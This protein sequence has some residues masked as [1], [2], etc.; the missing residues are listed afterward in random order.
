MNSKTNVSRATA[1]DDVNLL[2]ENVNN[3]EKCRRVLLYES[4][5]WTIRKA[6]DKRLQA[7]EMKFMR[8]TAGFTLLDHK[9]NEEILEKL[10]VVPVSKF[11]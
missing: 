4:E 7:A 10:K 1:D 6:G 9:R 11:I 8:K 2:D 5:V 3:K